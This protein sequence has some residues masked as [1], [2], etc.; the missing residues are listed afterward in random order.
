LTGFGAQLDPN[1]PI[2]ILFFTYLSAHGDY[3]YQSTKSD[4]SDLEIMMET[5]TEH[6]ADLENEIYEKASGENYC[7]DSLGSG[8]CF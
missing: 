4:K 6:S 3:Y 2:R 7:G 5:I 8:K 1:W